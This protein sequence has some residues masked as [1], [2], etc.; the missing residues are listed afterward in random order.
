MPRR[1]PRRPTIITAFIA[2][3][4][5]ALFGATIP[6]TAAHAASTCDTTTLAQA[7]SRILG[8]V[9]AARVNAK[10]PKVTANA[11]MNTVA[12]NWSKKQAAAG[13]MSHNPYYSTQIP[14]GWRSAGENVAAGYAI[15]QVSAAW[16]AS[17]GHK[18]NI[19]RSSFTHIGI[20][21]ACSASGKPFYTQVFAGYPPG[22]AGVTAPWNL[23][24]ATPTIA[25]TV[26]AN[27]TLT[28]RPGTWTTGTTFRY[29]WYVGGVAVTGATK[30]TFVPV[31]AQRG[32]TVTVKIT[33][34][35]SGYSTTSRTSRAT[36]PIA[37]LST[38]TRSTP[39]IV[40]NAKVG[41]VL[42]VRLG[43]WTT[44]TAFWYQWKASGVAIAGA[45][46]A[47]YVPRAADRGKTLTVEVVARKLGYFTVIARTP[48]T[49][50]IATGTLVASVPTIAGSPVAGATL[51]ATPGT[52]TPGTVLAYRWFADGAAVEGASQAAFTPPEGHVGAVL[53]VRVT[54]TLNGFAAR[55]MTSAATAPVAAAPSS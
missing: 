5:L 4:G 49:A 16:M 25:G 27:F 44:G 19:I 48:A 41:A 14:K 45:T 32:K 31:H 52:W 3:L 29:Q 43:T 15:S 8:E 42:T 26:K 18:A 1:A 30:S 39:T 17:A 51:T 53:T 7:Q 55:T 33:G 20:G 12:T 22:V 13:V 24:A 9:N 36:A 38:L 40:G 47:T 6:A 2:T 37:G 34:S 10:V 35:K 50:A 46:K 28:A 23:T 11:A 21:L 54:G